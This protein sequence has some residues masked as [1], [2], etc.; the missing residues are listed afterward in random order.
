MSEKRI[1]I[2]YKP[3]SKQQQ[4]HEDLHQFRAF[5]GGVGSGK[6]IA[7]S[8]ET[9]KFIIN[10]P[11]GV[12]VIAAPTYPM[13]RDATLRTFFEWCPKELIKEYNRSEGI[14]KFV[15]GSEILTRSCDDPRTIERIRGLTIAGFWIDEAAMVDE[16]AWKVLIARLRQKP[17]NLK[18]WITTTPRGYNWIYRRFVSERK[19]NYSIIHCSSKDNP[20]LTKEYISELEGSYSGVFSRQEIEGEFVG[21]EGLV[22]SDFNRNIHVI[23]VSE[24]KFF[25]EVIAGVDWGYTNPSVIL[26]VGID[27]NNVFYIVEEFYKKKVDKDELVEVAVSLRNK[28]NISVFYCD[29]SEPEFIDKFRKSGLNAVKGNN[30]VI[31]GINEVSVKLKIINNKS[32]LYVN[33]RCVNTIVEFENY[34]YPDDKNNKVSELPLKVYDHAMDALRY[35]IM[36]RQ[37]AIDYSPSIF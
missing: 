14:I 16:L 3:H 27:E 17:Y 29:P 13:L 2:Y 7:G 1:K 30:S 9:I 11:G 18:G 23:E 20:Y 34:R 32:K 31:A 35:A 10:N 24:K 6:T 4:F 5:V 33:N 37:K 28:Y 26:V 8:I 21:F 15:N 19:N 25:K 12:F 22:Y 36:G